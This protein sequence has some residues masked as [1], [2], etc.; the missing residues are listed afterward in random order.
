LRAIIKT[1]E[2]RSPA[3][4]PPSNPAQAREAARKLETL[5][6]DL[7]PGAADFVEANHSALR[8]LFGTESWLKFQQLVRSYAFEEAHEQLNLA[9]RDGSV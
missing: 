4:A 9:L 7:D 1:D 6:S 3:A 8:P 2:P 5:L